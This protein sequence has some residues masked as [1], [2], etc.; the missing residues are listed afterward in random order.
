MQT[1]RLCNRV[2]L[3]SHSNSAPGRR[4]DY[5]H[6]QVAAVRTFV[7]QCS[8]SHNVCKRLILNFD[9]VWTTMRRHSRRVIHKP[10][11]REG[12]H[13]SSEKPSRQ[14][15]IQSIRQA[16][17]IEAYDELGAEQTQD[18]YQVQP[19]ILNA[20]ANVS[21]IE[22]WRIPRTTCAISWADGELA[23]AWVTVKDGAAPDDVIQKLNQELAGTI[24]IYSHD[25]RSHVWNSSTVLH[26]LS[27]L[28]VEIRRKRLKRNLTPA[29][30]Y[31]LVLCDKATVHACA[32]FESI[33][34]RWE[35]ENAA[36][37]CHGSSSDTVKI[38]PGWGAAGAPNDGFHQWYHLLRQSFQKIATGQAR[39]L[40]LRAALT[41]LSIAVDGSVRYTMLGVTYTGVSHKSVT[42]TVLHKSVFQK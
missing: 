24:H 4:L 30:G 12:Q 18:R 22:G 16:L 39:S 19:V 37:I 1:Y 33:R 29:D 41:D 11:E 27:Y 40:E 23:S 42:P 3:R 25:S 31:A 7:Q 9:Q 6:P 14:R 32:A 20:Q 13:P 35:Q 26:F 36:L 21:P 2:G 15:M 28:S 17:D 5:E 34:K 38:P 8:Q 10:L